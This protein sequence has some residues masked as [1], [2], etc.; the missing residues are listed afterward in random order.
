MRVKWQVKIKVNLSHI[1]KKGTEKKNL[2]EVT[3]ECHEI[4]CIDSCQRAI[5]VVGLRKHR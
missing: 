4:T 3:V 5:T 2:D 1:Y